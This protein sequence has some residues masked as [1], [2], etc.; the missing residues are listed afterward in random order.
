MGTDRCRIGG[1][2]A[3]DGG[4]HVG[5]R[6][7]GCDKQAGERQERLLVVGILGQD[8]IV[9]LARAVEVSLHEIESREILRGGGVI[10]LD[11]RVPW[12]RLRAR[13]RN[14]VLTNK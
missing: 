4:F 6:C 10:G 12:R 13:Q 5:R 11:L 8:L 7:V 14:H 1:N 2:G 3:I 9:A